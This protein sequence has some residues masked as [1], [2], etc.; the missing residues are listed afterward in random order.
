MSPELKAA[1]RS[2]L[3]DLGLRLEN[4][5][6]CRWEA[7]CGGGSDR[8]FHRLRDERGGSWIV[9][10][11]SDARE[12]NALYPDIARFLREIRLNAPRLLFHD[13]ALRLIGLEDL[14]DEN[15]C[16]HFHGKGWN[17]ETLSL[18]RAALEQAGGLHRRASA[19]VHT[20]PGF[21]EVLYRWERH[22]FLENLVGRWAQVRL[23]AVECAAIEAEGERM[24]RDLMRHPLCL[25]HRDFQSQNL[26]VHAGMVWLID[27]Q[28]MRLGHAAY[29][30]ASLLYD[31]YVGLTPPQRTELL[32]WYV[33]QRRGEDQGPE[34]LEAQF[35]S[36][37]VQRLMQA[38]GAYGFLGIAKGKTRFLQYIP[39][40]LENLTEAL[41]RVGGMEATSA[42][43]ARLRSV[44]LSRS[45]DD[46][47]P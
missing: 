32:A 29:D 23:S 33:A 10:R 27:F 18:Y 17:A 8:E 31:P 22:Y 25:I 2:R 5:T 26:M 39:R 9:M 13:A 24:A 7:V 37:A 19:P 38:L 35:Y 4:K 36:A 14:G 28:G 6:D 43:V 47:S 15:L 40:G 42:L 1:A 12:E 45:T 41:G 20:M 46:G 3:R 16:S 11:Y 21:D 44:V 34:A 30:V